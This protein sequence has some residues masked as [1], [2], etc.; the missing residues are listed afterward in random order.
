M[1][2]GIKIHVILTTLGFGILYRFGYFGALHLQQLIESCMHISMCFLYFGV[3]GSFCV[4]LCGLMC[5]ARK[6]GMLQV[7]A[8][9]LD[10]W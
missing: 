5:C 10:F 7:G 1:P 3:F 2:K 6:M 4:G 9:F 8:Q